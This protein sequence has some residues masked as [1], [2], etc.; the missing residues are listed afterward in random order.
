VRSKE[1]IGGG[2]GNATATRCCSLRES[3]E[4]VGRGEGGD[5]KKKFLGKARVFQ[6]LIQCKVRAF[7][8][9]LW[10]IPLLGQGVLKVLLRVASGA[11]IGG[12]AP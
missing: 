9:V 7:T 11:V 3:G 12:H 6:L 5:Y 8:G 10:D 2:V 1:A 4:V